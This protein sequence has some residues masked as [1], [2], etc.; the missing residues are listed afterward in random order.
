MANVKPQLPQ[1]NY[2]ATVGFD[3]DPHKNFKALRV[4][5]DGD[6]S[7][8]CPCHLAQLIADGDVIDLNAKSEVE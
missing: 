5:K 2:V 6:A 7:K 1:P 8:V 3:I 4:E